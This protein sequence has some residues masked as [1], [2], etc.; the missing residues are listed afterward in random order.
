M[1]QEVKVVIR[2]SIVDKER[3]SN[4]LYLIL[5]ASAL[6]IIAIWMI[7]LTFVVESKLW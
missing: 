4:K 1:L 5:I 3:K 2:R 6:W 7:V